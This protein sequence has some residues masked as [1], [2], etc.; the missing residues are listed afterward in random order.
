MSGNYEDDYR[1][2]GARENYG[3]QYY[4]SQRGGGSQNRR[5]DRQH[6][7]RPEWNDRGRD[8]GHSRYDN[9]RDSD[10]NNDYNSYHLYRR[11]QQQRG[12]S[13]GSGQP[14]NFGARAQGDY[15]GGTRYG[16]GGGTY[17]GGSSYGHSYYGQS[18]NQGTRRNDSGR[19]SYYSENVQNGYGD[20]IDYN[21]RNYGSYGD[22]N[23]GSAYRSGANTGYNRGNADYNP[24]GYGTTRYNNRDLDRERSASRNYNS[25]N[26]N[27]D[28]YIRSRYREDYNREV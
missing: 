20:Y 14:A 11:D 8:F 26:P 25:G 7:N 3:R 2:Y 24:T 9:S 17:G 18:G 13:Y 5:D 15:S 6:Q 4:G 12:S 23:S 21:S 1:D 22:S 27:N 16:E 28:D 10:Y 19:D